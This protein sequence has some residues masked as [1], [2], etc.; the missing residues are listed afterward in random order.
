MSTSGGDLQLVV[1]LVRRGRAPDRLVRAAD[2]RHVA[3][4]E[5]R[6]PVPGL[7]DLATATLPHRPD[8]ALEGVEV[9]HRRRPEDRRPE[10]E[11]TGRLDGVVVLAARLES[12]DEVAQAPRRAGRARDGRRASSPAGGGASSRARGRAARSP[13]VDARPRGPASAAGTRLAS[14]AAA[15]RQGAPAGACR[16]R[17]WATFMPG[18]LASAP[19]TPHNAPRA[20]SPA[21]ELLD[22]GP[23]PEVHA[24]PDRHRQPRRD[25]DRPV[26]LGARL[27]LVGGRQAR[28]RHAAVREPTSRLRDRR[29]SPRRDG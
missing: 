12:F 15:S 21:Q 13:R 25:L 8:V 23:G 24:G 20:P 22:T 11:L 6:Q 27:A 16:S 2:L 26:H 29:A 10:D 28:R 9:A 14:S 4:V 7:G 19:G 17:T 5:D 3:E 1:E 18:S